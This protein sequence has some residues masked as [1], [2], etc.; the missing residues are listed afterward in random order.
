MELYVSIQKDPCE[1]YL[2]REEPSSFLVVTWDI[3]VEEELLSMADIVSL[4]TENKNSF[5]NKIWVFK[6]E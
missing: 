4:W 2:F 1:K 5:S 6:K 3:S